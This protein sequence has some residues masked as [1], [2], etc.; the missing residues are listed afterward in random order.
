MDKF[1]GRVEELKKLEEMYSIPQFQMAV[2]YGRRRV[3]KTT[4]LNEFCKNKKTIFCV[5]IESSEK[6]NR[7]A[8]SAALWQA[9]G[10]ASDMPPFEDF[11][12]FF[13]YIADLGRQERIVLVIDEY[14]YLAAAVPSVS[15]ILQNCIDHDMKNSE[16][17]LILCGSSMSFMEH[18]VLGYKSPLYGR[19]SAQFKIRPFSFW[20]TREYL[21]T[22]SPEEQ[23]VL[24]GVTGGVPEYLSHID[25]NQTVSDN[26]VKLFFLT[27]GRLFEE[28]SNLLKQELRDPTTYNAILTA[29]A[30]GHSRLNEIA[31]MV[32]IPSSGCSNLLVSLIELGIVYKETPIGENSGKKTL[33]AIQDQMFRFWFRFVGTNLSMITAGYGE[34]IFNRIVSERIPDFMGQVYEA[35]CRE[36]LLRQLAQNLTPIFFHQIGR[37][38]GGN[39]HTK[40]QEEVDILATDG[41]AAIIAECKWRNKSIDLEVLTGL[42][43]KKDLFSYQEKYLYIFSKSGFT[44]GC[45]EE[46][47]KQPDVR[48]ISF[49]EQI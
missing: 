19:R 10:Q 3:G 7:K 15:S 26:L 41:E 20:E 37:W 24:Y 21:P 5:G 12:S 1:V 23:A 46:A 33:Y 14:P 25:P 34:Q 47:K 31:T 32:G 16:V 45:R 29:I 18:Q 30:N 35:I 6:E 8:F 39:P 43:R 40:K 4:L 44:P 13:N 49:E 42:C 36:W 27:S 17:F 11:G 48:L 9:M 2:M 28:P 22:F 38:W